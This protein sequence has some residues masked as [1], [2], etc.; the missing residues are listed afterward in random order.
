V[1]AGA[2]PVAIERLAAPSTADRDAILALE[3]ASFSNPW[4]AETFDRML[5]LP[6]SR[7]YAARTAD[8]HIVAFCACWFIKDELHINTLAVAAPLRRHGIAS[9][10]LAA[11]LADT[12]AAR[13]TLEVRRSNAAAIRL[14]EKFGFQVTAV[15]QRYYENP[16]EDGLILWLNP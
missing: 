11:V 14:Y 7:I 12:G 13:A 15:R 8:G 9:R 16:E 4:T 10:L 5:A 2:V 3:A 1:S 6:V